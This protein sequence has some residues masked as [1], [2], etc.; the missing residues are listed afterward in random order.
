MSSAMSIQGNLLAA[1]ILPHAKSREESK[2]SKSGKHDSVYPFSKP[3]TIILCRNS[4]A[5][6]PRFGRSERS[7]H[8]LPAVTGSIRRIMPDAAEVSEV[9]SISQIKR[10]AGYVSGS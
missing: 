10:K 3:K 4:V 5:Y 2:Q 6:A 8:S 9:I 1:G 7:S